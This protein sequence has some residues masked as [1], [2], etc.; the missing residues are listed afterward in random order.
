MRDSSLGRIV[1]L[2]HQTAREFLLQKVAE[3]YYITETDGNVEIA[4]TC[5]RIIC[6]VFSAPILQTEAEDTFSETEGVAEHLSSH[7]LLL[8]ALTNF[9]NH[10][11]HLG[12]GS[13]DVLL[14]FE[15]FLTQLSKQPNSYA[16]FLLSQWIKSN[17]PKKLHIN[18]NETAVR[19][20]I[21]AT[22]AHAMGTESDNLIKIVMALQPNASYLDI[23]AGDVQA[24]RMPLVH[25]DN[26]NR[27]HNIAQPP[28]ETDSEDPIPSVLWT[29][30]NPG[31]KKPIPANLITSKLEDGQN[32]SSN[33]HP[34]E[35]LQRRQSN[36]A[37]TINSS[38]QGGGI[39]H[40]VSEPPTDSGYASTHPVARDVLHKSGCNDEYMEN[41]EIEMTEED[42]EDTQT[43]YSLQSSTT[44]SRQQIFISELATHIFNA[45]KSFHMDRE[46]LKQI[47]HILP[48]LLKAFSLKIGHHDSNA[49]TEM[50]RD[51]MVFIHRYRG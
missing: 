18:A 41:Y 2:I 34:N 46:A 36:R 45:T 11:D 13:K 44:H 48:E 9:K 3:P 5:C 31:S 19:S 12:V 50:H 24:T 33:V 15:N 17:L 49:S 16:C 30:G 4:I 42:I 6:I 22:L 32:G 35:S 7:F 27:R 37:D 25:G 39:Q 43:E 14:Q 28:T 21:D 51:A 38:I 40:V 10:L 47:L 26:P 1:Q 8:Y 23:E 20:C 29:E